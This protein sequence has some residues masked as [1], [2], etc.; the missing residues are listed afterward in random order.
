[1]PIRHFSHHWHTQNNL[2]GLL[3]HSHFPNLPPYNLFNIIGQSDLS[4]SDQFTLSPPSSKPWLGP[5]CSQ[6]KIQ[7]PPQRVIRFFVPWSLLIC[8]CSPPP[9]M[10]KARAGLHLANS[11]H[12]PSLPWLDVA[13][14]GCH[15]P[16]Y[17]PLLSLYH[18]VTPLLPKLTVGSLKTDDG[19]YGG[20]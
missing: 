2:N 14:L 17:L 3:K 16:L 7:T 12:S 15:S 1:M 9:T 5:H 20:H 11:I 8:S 18:W 19:A 4:K 10:L 13:H 6:D